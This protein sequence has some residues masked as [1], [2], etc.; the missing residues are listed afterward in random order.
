MGAEVPVFE[1]HPPTAPAYYDHLP[2]AWLRH[3]DLGR[4]DLLRT[5]DSWSTVLGKPNRY[6]DYDV[7][8]DFLAGIDHDSLD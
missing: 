6:A 7:C 3:V 1:G 2:D 4:L 5:L 8:C